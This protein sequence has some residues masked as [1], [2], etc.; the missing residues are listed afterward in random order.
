MNQIIGFG[1]TCLTFLQIGYL[2]TEKNW[3]L[4]DEEYADAVKSSQAVHHISDLMRKDLLFDIEEWCVSDHTGLKVW[5][6]TPHCSEAEMV[7][8]S[9]RVLTLVLIPWKGR[10]RDAR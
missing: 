5:L 2:D 3:M 9:G 8:A 4:D 7:V 10:E 6:K 1:N